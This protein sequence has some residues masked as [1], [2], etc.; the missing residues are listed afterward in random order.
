MSTEPS[1]RF[2]CARTN[3]LG[4]DP[5]ELAT[6]LPLGIDSTA[7]PLPEP[8]TATAREVLEA[9]L[10]PALARPPC[11]LSFSGGRDSSAMLA[12]ATLVA[13]RKALPDPI[14]VT[15]RFPA[16]PSTDET[17]WQEHFIAHLGLHEWEILNFNEELE[18]LGEMATGLLRAHGQLWPATTHLNLPAL[19]RARGGSM[20]VSADLR[21]LLDRW[22]FAR[23][24]EVMRG[25][26]RPQRR[27]ARRV[28]IALTPRTVRRRLGRAELATRF[29][30]LRPAAQRLLFERVGGAYNEPGRWDRWLGRFG[31][32][33]YLA[34]AERSLAIVAREQDVIVWRPIR[35]PAF[36]AALARDG[37]AS[38]FGGR[39]G[40]TPRLFGDLL[41]DAVLM[42]VPTR[43]EFRGVL[44][45]DRSRAFARSW[46]GGGVDHE[47]V[48]TET[49]RAIWTGTRSDFHSSAAAVAQTAWLAALER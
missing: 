1:R 28:A 7:I 18:I 46:A 3:P 47:L 31:G 25:R 32:L 26:V 10:M 44:W 20:L 8:S 6:G 35:S 11:V 16:H 29:P 40:I 48:D 22:R 45:G 37:G 15:W 14:P 4:L 5:L 49:L 24:H 27:D 30:W 34:L 36:L 12:L 42:R 19:T 9:E 38:G 41:P 2:S 17:R 23:A 13:R 33:R 21:D 39:A 43:A